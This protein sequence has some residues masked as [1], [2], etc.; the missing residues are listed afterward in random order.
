MTDSGTD[1]TTLPTAAGNPAGNPLLPSIEGELRRPKIPLLYRLGLVAVSLAM[2]LLPLL[3]FAIIG[4]TTYGLYCYAVKLPDLTDQ[5]PGLLLRL[6]LVAPIFAGLVYIFFLVKPL[7]APQAEPA[8]AFS[9]EH[10]DAPQLFALIGWIC[11]SLDAPIPSRVDVN[12]SINAGVG[13]RGGLRS[14]FGNALCSS[15]GCRR[16][17][18]LT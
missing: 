16:W 4:L 10:A 6:L 9:I 13:F 2:I 18:A 7:F 12:L 3:Y 11:R 15:S 14:L 17:R 8:R 1:K 5:V